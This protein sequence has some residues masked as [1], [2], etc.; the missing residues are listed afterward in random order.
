MAIIIHDYSYHY[1]WTFMIISYQS[2]KLLNGTLGAQCYT[3]LKNVPGF[4]PLSVLT[5]I[6]CSMILHGVNTDSIGVRQPHHL[7][8]TFVRWS[9]RN[10]CSPHTMTWR[11][12]FRDR[13][14]T[15]KILLVFYYNMGKYA[16][17]THRKFCEIYG[18]NAASE[19]IQLWFVRFHSG[20]FNVKDAPLSG[21]A[22]N[23]KPIIFATWGARPVH[24]LSEPAR[25]LNIDK[26]TVWNR[27]IRTN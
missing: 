11:E 25:A 15:K 27:L 7:S 12:S 13:S 6:D 1:L 26:L 3:S 20:D 9:E 24:K 4:L 17:E 19:S 5:L 10:S 8:P 23:E 16:A 21:R 2:P 18:K 14:R 22:V